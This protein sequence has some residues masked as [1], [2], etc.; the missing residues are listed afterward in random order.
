MAQQNTRARQQQRQRVMIILV[1]LL[2]AGGAAFFLLG[3]NDAKKNNAPRPIPKGLIGVPIAKKD[4]PLGTRISNNLISISYRRPREVP[5]DALLARGEF[6]GRFVTKPILEGQYIQQSDVGVEGA[7]GGFSAMA[8]YGKRLIVLNANLFPGSLETLKVGDHIDLLAF[9][10]FKTAATS[11]SKKFNPAID[12]AQPGA[13]PKRDRNRNPTGNELQDPTSPATATLI[14][15]NAEVMSVPA[16]KSRSRSRRSNNGGDY[17]VLQMNPQDAH[18]TTLMA[19]SN[20]MLRAVFRPY[21]D[22]TRLTQD[23]PA[24]L[25]T[26]LPRSVLDPDYIQ[27]IA[28]GKTFVTK[29]NSRIFLNEESQSKQSDEN[30]PKLIYGKPASA[31][32]IV[33]NDENLIANSEPQQLNGNEEV[34]LEGQ[35]ETKS[36]RNKVAIQNNEVNEE[37]DENY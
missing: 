19:A 11:G 15:E 16:I 6:I 4:M 20:V 1:F 28:D 25:T 13:A 9:Q 22:Q 23:S 29:P 2:V 21:G 31:E 17:V 37:T 27:V 26:R 10:G 14:A 30:A 8:T 7:V 18:V 24:S 3:N 34:R 36:K 5:T 35:V 32:V 33:E 12:G